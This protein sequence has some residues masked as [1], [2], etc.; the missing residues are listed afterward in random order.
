MK[1][2][3]IINVAQDFTS[4]P[5]ARYKTDGQYSGEEFR[6]KFIEPLFANFEDNSEIVIVLDG[7]VGQP[8]SF[9]EES[10]GGMARIAGVERCLKRFRFV[11]K[12]DRLVVE[13]ILSYIKSAKKKPPR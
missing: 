13:E 3:N 11:S 4:T 7:L 2:Q 10:F 12:E 1:S 8:T 6:E 9:L 5:G